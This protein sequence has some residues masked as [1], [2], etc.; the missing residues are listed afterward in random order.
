LTQ[1][2][3][4]SEQRYVDRAYTRLEDMRAHA[5]R[6][7]AQAGA[8][9][10]APP[11][12]RRDAFMR[13]GLNRAADLAIGDEPLV[14][15]RIDARDEETLYIGRTAVYDESHDPLVT[16][17]RAPVAESFYRATPLN[18]MGLVRRRHLICRGPK[19]VGLEDELLDAPAVSDRGLVMV[20]EGA[21]LDAL[22]RTRTGRMRDIVA[23]IQAEQDAVIRAPLEGA[24]VVQGGPGTGKTAVALHRAAYLLYTHRERLR[25]SGVLIVGPNPIFL[26]YIEQVLPSLGETATLA[27]VAELVHD[28]NVSATESLD[29]ARMKGDPRMAGVIKRGIDALPSELSAPAELRYE[30]RRI[31][32][33]VAESRRLVRFA[34][35]RLRGKHNARGRQ[36]ARLVVEY[37]WEKWARSERTWVDILGTEGRRNFEETVLGDPVLGVTLDAMWPTLEAHE[38]VG[39]LLS[40]PELLAVA[41]ADALSRAEQALLLR[42][43]G[44]FWTEAD[45]ALIDEAGVRLGPRASAAGAR[46]PTVDEEERWMVERM[47]DDLQEANPLIG[48]MR[49]VLAERY[50]SDRLEL[51]DDRRDAKPA[52]PTRFGHVIVDE[53]QGLSPMQW[54]MIDRRCRSGSMTVVGDLGQAGG[55]WAPKSWEEVLAHARARSVHFEELTINYRTPKD[56]MDVAARVLASV[57]PELTP[58]RS[59]RET[60]EAPEFVAVGEAQLI[61]AVAAAARQESARVPDGKVAVLAA[62]VAVDRLSVALGVEPNKRHTVAMLDEPVAVLSVDE[63]RGL[64]FDS[65]VVVEPAAIVE[66]CAGGLRALYVALTRPTHRLIVVHAADLPAAM[67]G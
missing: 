22:H 45:A 38:F 41:S 62:P 67:G 65:V 43:P 48:S 1:S 35:E 27:T 12:P 31:V 42:E 29:V 26:R 46:G 17:W 56:V 61:D 58:P 52:V 14:F 21:L 23:T 34:R 59:V 57:A 44:A 53:A 7:V 9:Y 18:P 36:L 13:A 54:R 11:G 55:A 2:E 39:G 64:E 15:G 10:L 25:R 32:L 47:L 51:E 6:I 33:T 37:L 40:S 49:G 60:G 20:G 30:G 50:A 5:Q 28:V 4:E 16:D 8:R 3:L 24:L 19:I 66:T 63:A